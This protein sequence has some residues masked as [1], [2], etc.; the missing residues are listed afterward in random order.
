MKTEL[1]TDW[2][3]KDI[4]KGFYYDTNEDKGVS[5]LGGKLIIQPE[6]QR[7][8]I[9]GGTGRDVAVVNS[10]IKG[11]PLGLMYFVKISDEKDEKYEVLDGQQRIT[12]FAR[13]VND[14]HSF[15]IEVDGRKHIFTSLN[16]DL[17]NKIN[18]TKLTI[19]ICEGEPSEIQKWFEIVNIAGVPLTEQ[20]LRNTSYHG[21]FVTSARKIFSNAQNSNMKRWRTYVKGD[22]R[23][24]A[25]LEEAINWV[26]GGEIDKYMSVHRNDD[27]ITELKNYF[28]SVINWIGS[29]FEYNGSEIK[30]HDWGELYRKFHNNSYTRQ[31]VTERVNELMADYQVRNK[32]GIFEYIL[33]GEK[34]KQLLDIRVFDEHIKKIVYEKQTRE[35]KG[36][37]I[38]NCPLCALEKNSNHD[39]IYKITEMEADHVTA[40]TKGGETSIENCQMLC[41]N[42][43]R[44]KGNK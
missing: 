8:Y 9:Y 38:S 18:N 3:V 5:G 15:S 10:L 36:K 12:S 2:T 35:A 24:Q 22:P 20:E 4:C 17:Q 32:R 7:N 11:Y 28:D 44:S 27:D 34:N 23:R 37:K 26:S 39:K 6:Y 33:D 42:H 14:S 29:I 16:K 31:K 40:W 25:I 41:K 13:F 19:Y 43:N 1:K 30:G 21:N